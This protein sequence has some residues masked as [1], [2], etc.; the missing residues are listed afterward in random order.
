M[1]G[2]YILL[3]RILIVGCLSSCG[4]NQSARHENYIIQSIVEDVNEES[5][6]APHYTSHADWNAYWRWRV[7][8]MRTTP[9]GERYARMAIEMR[10]SAGLPELRK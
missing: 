3:V 4:M 7:R 6:G 1:E 9:D 8:N 5:K 10:R 2:R